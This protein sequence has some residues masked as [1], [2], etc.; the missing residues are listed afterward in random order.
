MVPRTV[1][2]WSDPISVNDVR[3]VN[4][5]QS[6]TAV[7]NAESMKNVINIAY[8]TTKRPFNK[9]TVVN[10]SNFTK[11]VNTVKGTRVNT[12]RPK[13]VVSAVKENK[14]NAV[15]ALAC[16]VWRPKNQV[17]DHV[18][19]NNSALMSFKRFDYIDAQGRSK[20]MTGNKSY[21]IDYEEINKGFVAF[22]GNSKEG[23]ITGK[24]K[25]RTSKLDFEDVYF[26]KELKFILFSVSQMCDKK[27]SVL[28]TDIECVVLSPDFKLTD[29]SHVLLKVPR[30][31]NM[32]SV[33]LKNVVPQGGLTCLFPKATPDESNL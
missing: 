22:G 11:K 12:A 19:R 7:N 28:F 20:H 25:I 1:L 8:S 23:K 3:P 29:E 6:R 9:I 17:L 27:N 30:K 14:R 4:T 21:L 26:V 13:A 33:D 24:G 16:W 2:T 32:Y 18:S 5:V 10:N 31:D 15:K